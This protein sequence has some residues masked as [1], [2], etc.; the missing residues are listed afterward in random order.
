MIRAFLLRLDGGGFIKFLP[1]AVCY[2]N[3]NLQCVINI[4]IN[5][6]TET[7]EITERVHSF[8]GKFP[9]HLIKK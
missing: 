4:N 9:C 6:K 5:L 8:P 2:L 7:E 1:K 3:I